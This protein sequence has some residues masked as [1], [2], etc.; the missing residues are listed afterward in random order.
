M[1]KKKKKKQKLH[2]EDSA[3]NWMNDVREKLRAA[4]SK[5]KGSK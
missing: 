2:L 1:S 4:D 5:P 3:P